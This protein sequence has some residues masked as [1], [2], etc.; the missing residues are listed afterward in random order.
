L[1][2]II[3]Y[4]NRQSVNLFFICLVLLVLFFYF[5]QQV[6]QFGGLCFIK[7]KSIILSQ[8]WSSTFFVLRENMKIIFKQIQMH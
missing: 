5:L 3:F 8:E 7:Y 2:S 1:I 4:L 6:F